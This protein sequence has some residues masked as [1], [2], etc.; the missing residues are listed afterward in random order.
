MTSLL[1]HYSIA[2]L[3]ITS[4]LTTVHGQD[5]KTL[6]VDELF[7]RARETA[8]AGKREE[9]RA[10]LLT[11]LER[12]PDYTDVRIFLA[13]T[14]AWDG[15]RAQAR[16]EL[17]TVLAQSPQHEDALN[18]LVDVEM[19]DN[20][21]AYG[22][23][24]VNMALS[25]YPNSEDLL[26]KKAS[27]L[28][29]LNRPDEAAVV[30]NQLLSINPSHEKG[31]AL[32]DELRKARMKYTAGVSYDLDLFSR[33]FSPAHSLAAQL[34]RANQWGS[35]IIR[36]NY[37]HRFS[38][39]GFQ[40]EIDLYPRIADGI[41]AYLNYGYSES[42][43]FPQHRIGAEVFSKLPASL[44]ASAGI[45]YL[46]FGSTSKVTIYT[47]SLGWYYKSYWFSLR[48]YITPGEP[49]TSFSTNLTVRRYFKDAD[50]Y[51]GLTGGYGFSP[52]DRRIQSA[53]GLSTDGIYILK[54][55]RLG[56]A[57]QKTFKRNFILNTSL[58]AVHQE[59]SFDQGQYV[60]ITN[61][62]VGIRKR[63]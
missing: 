32:L 42:D 23:T 15:M 61:I 56:V 5:W 12:N 19:W 41:Y 57:W 25:Y 50:N 30:L 6:G 62:V 35:S 60:W 37:A 34:A 7:Q 45:R 27:I 4:I 24:V 33:T 51:I 29:S 36:L 8:F 28:N 2:F 20:Q 53:A 39:N 38:S 58:G 49:G 10:M 18:A 43:L 3:L 52:D 9:A 63:F 55:Q 11:I 21:F 1:R 40:P 54:S 16:K 44:E 46:Y 17:Q 13:R 48:P 14:Y 22:L 59:L 31:I 26:Y 47:G